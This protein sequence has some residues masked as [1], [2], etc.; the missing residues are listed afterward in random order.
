MLEGRCGEGV[1]ALQEGWTREGRT[2]GW[3]QRGLGEVKMLT[4]VLGT[5]SPPC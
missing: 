2:R 1:G 3:W 4:L 5:C